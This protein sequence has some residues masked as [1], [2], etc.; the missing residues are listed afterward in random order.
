MTNDAQ[1]YINKLINKGN[2]TYLDLSNRNLA[3]D[4]NLVD[5]SRLKNI[6][7]YG[8]K[9]ANLDFL[10]SLPNKNKLEKINFF[11]NEIGQ[12]DFAKLF[13]EFPNLQNINLENNPSGTN[14]TSLN[15][16]QFSQLVNLV[17]EKKVK[18]NS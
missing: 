18:I 5:F 15:D 7:A 14:F 6:N 8:N 11:G 3:G 12:V 2:I 1:E 17:E 9:F 10:F 16:V 13:T 4:M